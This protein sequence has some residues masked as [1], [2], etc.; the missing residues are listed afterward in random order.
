M[1][2]SSDDDD[3]SYLALFVV[4]TLHATFLGGS[5]QNRNAVCMRVLAPSRQHPCP[6]SRTTTRR[7]YHADHTGTHSAEVLQG[8]RN[9]PTMDYSDCS[10]ARGAVTIPVCRWSKGVSVRHR[11]W[12]TLT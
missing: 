7:C 2:R 4:A 6:N 12:K 10:P 1:A 3:A 5:H 8:L 11:V 9:E